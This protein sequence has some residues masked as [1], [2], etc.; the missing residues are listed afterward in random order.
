MTSTF[1]SKWL[2]SV[3]QGDLNRTQPLLLAIYLSAGLDPILKSVDTFRAGSPFL[4]NPLRAPEHCLSRAIK[5]DNKLEIYCL[6]Y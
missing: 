5:F 2:F 3:F 4:K 1:A 6:I